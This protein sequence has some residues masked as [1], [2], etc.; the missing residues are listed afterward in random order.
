MIVL[1]NRKV[2]ISSIL[3]IIRNKKQSIGFVPTMGA[4][5]QGHISLV[6]KSLLENNITV[7]SIFVNPT[8]FNDKNDLQN[9]PRTLENDIKLLQNLKKTIYIFAPDVQEMYPKEDNRIFEL[10]ELANTM[11][12]AHRPGHFNGMWQIVSKLFTVIQPTNAYFGEKDFQQL[13]I[14]KYMT[15]KEKR[16]IQIIPCEIVR[17]DDGLAMSSRNQ[18]LTKENRLNAPKIYEI[19]TKNAPL[20]K[21]NPISEVIEQIKNELNNIKNFSVE[22]VSV[23]Q[24]DNLEAATTYAP[25]KLRLFVAVNVGEVRL[26]DNIN[27]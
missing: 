26:I 14:I 6:K 17:E 24:Q 8:Q 21:E 7:V 25:G 2:E 9:Y 22:Y 16:K 12:G 27:I 20:F 23:V 11:E 18:R 3:S 19:L 15:Q 13:A 1:F 4:L 5:H 10:G